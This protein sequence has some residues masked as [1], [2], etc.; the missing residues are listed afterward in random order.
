MAAAGQAS[1]EGVELL[2]LTHGGATGRWN[3]TGGVAT[4]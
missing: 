2:I 1:S 3:C 4:E